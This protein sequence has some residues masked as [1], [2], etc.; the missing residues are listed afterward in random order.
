MLHIAQ[1]YQFI[2]QSLPLELHSQCI[3]SVNFR[4]NT[5]LSISVCL[6]N[7]RLPAFYVQVSNLETIVSLQTGLAG[8]VTSVHVHEP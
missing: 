6:C 5:A 1:S 2:I 3:D 7:R 8:S 4:L